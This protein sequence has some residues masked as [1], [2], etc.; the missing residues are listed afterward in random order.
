M[1]ADSH[2]HLYHA[3]FDADR[4][5]AV[6]RALDAGVTTVFLPATD[7]ATTHAALALAERHPGVVYAMAGVH[8]CDVQH[9]N[10]G[11]WEAI[12]RLAHDPRVVGIGE[13]G[14]DHYWSRD[15]DALQEEMLRRHARLAAETGKPLVLHTRSADAEVL[16]VVGEEQARLDDPARLRGVFHCWSGTAEQA[17]EAVAMGFCVGVGGSSTYKK[18][19]VFEALAE[20]PLERIV[21]ET[22]APYLAPVPHRGQR[23]EPA[24]VA[25]TAAA[26]AA[27]R[28]V[29]VD[30][31]ARATTAATHRLYGRDV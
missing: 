26:L 5:E 25:H 29:S 1:F 30:E 9:L 31:V 12:E 23:N 19:T 17:A 11:D 7:L 13:T 3:K 22:D 15:F 21:L 6:R 14:L 28:G 18:S 10:D 2:C 24:F 8:P 16:R 4:A 20:V 27:A